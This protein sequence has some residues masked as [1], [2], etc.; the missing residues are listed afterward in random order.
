MCVSPAVSGADLHAGVDLQKEVLPML[1][2]HELHCARIVV[3]DAACNQQRRLSLQPCLL[4]LGTVQ[5][6]TMLQALDQSDQ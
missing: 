3:P 6:G 4:L 5:W 1:V 2:H